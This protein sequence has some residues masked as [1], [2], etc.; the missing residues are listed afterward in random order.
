MGASWE[1]LLI[2]ELLRTL[3]AAGVRDTAYY[4]RTAGGAEVDLVLEGPFGL[5]PFEIK[6]TQNVNPRHLR[7]I[8]DF[9]RG[10]D[11]PFGIVINNDEKVRV[12]DE[13]LFGVPFALLVAQLS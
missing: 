1:G 2:E 9:I 11:C 12:Y 13:K 5:I 6:H 10:F 8:R 4:Y 3:N 7:G